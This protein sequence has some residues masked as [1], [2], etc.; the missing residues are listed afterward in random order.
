MQMTL[1]FAK[2]FY[3]LAGIMSDL[4]SHKRKVTAKVLRVIVP[5]MVQKV[6]QKEIGFPGC[7]QC[8]AEY[9]EKGGRV[10]YAMDAVLAQS[11]ED[12]EVTGDGG[13]IV[14]LEEAGVDVQE[15]HN[16]PKCEND[17]DYC[18]LLRRM[19]DDGLVPSG[20]YGP[21][22]KRVVAKVTEDLSRAFVDDNIQAYA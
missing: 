22:L 9:L 6:D 18:L 14:E 8:V 15:L 21:V 13:F 5:V 3:G 20:P 10:E 12:S 19:C 16:M 7:L 17:N 1:N 4:L 2:G 11:S